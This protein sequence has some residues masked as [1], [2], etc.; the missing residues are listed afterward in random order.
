[1]LEVAL[2]FSTIQALTGCSTQADPWGIAWANV[3]GVFGLDLVP[4]QPG[5]VCNVLSHLELVLSATLLLI[6]FAGLVGQVIPRFKKIE[7]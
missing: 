5:A 6:I 7:K 2:L 4:H 1:M 3:S